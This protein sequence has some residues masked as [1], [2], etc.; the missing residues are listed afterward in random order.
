VAGGENHH[1]QIAETIFEKKPIGIKTTGKVSQEIMDAAGNPYTVYFSHTANIDVYVNIQVNVNTQFEG[2]NGISE[3]RRNISSYID[4]L[5]I[6]GGV[7]LSA[8]YGE[9]HKVTGVE[10]VRSLKLSTDGENWSTSNISANNYE[11]C[12]CKQVT[13]EVI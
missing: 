11:D 5:G 13:V 1:Q 3:I 10:D 12:T 8:L 2:E 9:I 7:I 4:N 6:G